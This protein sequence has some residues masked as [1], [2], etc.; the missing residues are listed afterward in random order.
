MYWV[1]TVSPGI[2][3]SVWDSVMNKYTVWCQLP[4]CEEFRVMGGNQR[5][6]ANSVIS[7]WYMCVGVYKPL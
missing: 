6:A 2:V 5:W 7:V 3:V 1:P 4:P